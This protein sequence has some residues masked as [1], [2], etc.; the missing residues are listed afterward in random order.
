M[1]LNKIIAIINDRLQLLDIKYRC[2]E[3]QINSHNFSV[4]N[5]PMLKLLSACA[6]QQIIQISFESNKYYCYLYL[7]ISKSRNVAFVIATLLLKHINDYIIHQFSTFSLFFQTLFFLLN[8]PTYY[9]TFSN[10]S[11]LLYIFISPLL[12]ILISFFLYHF[13]FFYFWL[14]LFPTS[15]Y[16]FTILFLILHIVFPHT[17]CYLSLSLSLS[18]SLFIFGGFFLF[19]FFYNSILG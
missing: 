12:S 16:K 14:F 19:Y 15:Y 17:K 3:A 10:F 4:L 11:P 13:I 8:F 2:N 9:Y 1:W 18:L 6:F 5:L 7:Y